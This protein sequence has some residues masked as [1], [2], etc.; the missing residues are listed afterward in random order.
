MSEYHKLRAQLGASARHRPG[1]DRTDLKREFV[2]E[3]LARYVERVVAE[4][5]PLTDEQRQRIADLLAPRAGGG[6]A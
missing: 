5:P 4:A 6:A 1:E 3:K 2:T